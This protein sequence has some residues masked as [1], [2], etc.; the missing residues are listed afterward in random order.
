MIS[1]AV[2]RDIHY[3]FRWCNANKAASTLLI[4]NISE[5]S[6]VIFINYDFTTAVIINVPG[7]IYIQIH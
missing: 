2:W 4:I 7:T 1:R 6:R 5:S 3:Y